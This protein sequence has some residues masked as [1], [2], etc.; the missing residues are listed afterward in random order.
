[1]ICFSIP[2]SGQTIDTGFSYPFRGYLC[3]YFFFF[4]LYSTKLGDLCLVDVSPRSSLSHYLLNLSAWN[5]GVG[6]SASDFPLYSTVRYF[7]VVFAWKYTCQNL[8]VGFFFF[9]SNSLFVCCIIAVY[10]SLSEE[11]NPLLWNILHSKWLSGQ[12]HHVTNLMPFSSHSLAYT[13]DALKYCVS[14]YDILASC[15][16]ALVDK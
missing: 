10:C 13:S 7:W 15:D 8:E 11:L 1:M 9:F 16:L 2:L 4:N 14:T 3:I 6:S 5:L 12:T